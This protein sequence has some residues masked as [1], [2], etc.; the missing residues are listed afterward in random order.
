MTTEQ[1]QIII[2]ESIREAAGQCGCKPSEAHR[3]KQSNKP[4]MKARN[5][6]IRTARAQEIPVHFLANAFSL[7]R[8]TIQK[9][10]RA[11]VAV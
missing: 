9:A 4:G 2:I 6:A 5:I 11:E 1:A 8:E 10:L 7:S 3:P